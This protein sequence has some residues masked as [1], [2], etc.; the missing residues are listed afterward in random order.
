MRMLMT[1]AVPPWQ[2]DA[3]LEQ[4]VALCRE[5]GVSDV[6]VMVQVHPEVEP[7]LA[8]IEDAARR[9]A[10]VQARLRAHGVA[11]GI[12]L[13]TLL[14]HGERGYPISP[15]PFQR[16]V[17]ADGREVA[18]CFCPLDPDFRA[19]VSQAVALLAAT[20]PAFMLVDDDVRIG[21]HS[22]ANREC[23]CPLH[24]DAYRRRTGQT[25]TRET[26][27]AAVCRDDHEGLAVRTAWS[28][29]QQAGLV[30]FT[31]TVRTA[32][33]T[34]DPT[35]R[36]GICVC[37]NQLPH[38]E[39]MAR[40]LA[41][42]A[43]PLLRLGNAYYLEQGYKN[44]PNVMAGIAHQRTRLPDDFE[45]LS[46][47]D[48]WPQTRY[49]LSATG[50]RGYI[51]CAALAGA[52]LPE[53]WVTNLQ[54]WGPAEGDAYRVM[55]R[56][57]RPFFDAVHA[58]GR[59]VQ[60]QGPIALNDMRE[61][62]RKPWTPDTSEWLPAPSWGGVICGRLGLPFRTA[63]THGVRMIAGDAPWGFTREE[64]LGFL[65]E[66]ML[67]DGQ[68]ALHLN[69]MGLGE[70]L[71]VDVA[72][73]AALRPNFE[74]FGD[75]RALNGTSAGAHHYIMRPHLPDLAQLTPRGPAT[76]VASWL[77][78]WPG[79]QSLDQQRL[80]PALTVYTN[81]LG[82]RIAVYAHAVP[83][84]VELNFLSDTRKEQLRQVLAWVAGEPLPVATVD[85]AD[86]YVQYGRLPAGEHLLLAVNVN[87]DPVSPLRLRLPNGP[88]EALRLLGGDGNWHPGDC[89]YSDGIATVPVCVPTMQPVV[90]RW[91]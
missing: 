67:L 15:V 54:E 43:R 31:Q 56:E 64:L 85:T 7:L 65:T 24:L 14:D 70:Y 41:G 77:M 39:E 79:F 26:L 47:A 44:F 9:F 51:T 17:G 28:A 37:S 35:L 38:A 49:S 86:C 18:V 12:L 48:T 73:G 50:L 87:T 4:L 55:L 11:A 30:R 33:D 76:Q 74:Q 34:V 5:T 42:P 36:G 8:K 90:L 13:Q 29:A 25:L 52:D 84:F 91:R 66:G 19:Y 20:R 75:D 57:S 45:Y 89:Q 83:G 80:A 81:A 59:Q 68:A 46:E 21:G 27:L 32:M 40:I 16:I 2:E 62:Y 71:G 82:G 3:V 78:A 6:A 23:C 10:R 53:V 72:S 63:G 88:P 58:L 1:V 69:R 22:P 61:L 60:W